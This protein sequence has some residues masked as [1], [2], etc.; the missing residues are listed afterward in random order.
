MLEVVVEDALGPGCFERVELQLGVLVGGADPCVSDD[1]HRS[2]C[3][4]GH[5]Y[6]R[7]FDGRRRAQFAYPDGQVLSVDI[8]LGSLAESSERE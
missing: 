7:L 3:L 4:I 6:Y 1:G 5:G 2:A 8:D